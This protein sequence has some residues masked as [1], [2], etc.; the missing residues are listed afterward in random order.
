MLKQK[1]PSHAAATI[2][3]F[4]AISS[5]DTALAQANV[6]SVNTREIYI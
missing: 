5:F 4:L 3:P 1:H 6:H 2:D